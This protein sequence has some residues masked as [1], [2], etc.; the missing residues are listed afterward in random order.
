M[1]TCLSIV[2]VAMAS[3]T[4]GMTLSSPLEDRLTSRRQLVFASTF[5]RFP[6]S[7]DTPS[8]LFDTFK[9]TPVTF[10][11]TDRPSSRALDRGREGEREREE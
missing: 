5:G 3:T 4:S 6:G 9:L 1:S 10:G 7:L 8:S 11:F 2:L